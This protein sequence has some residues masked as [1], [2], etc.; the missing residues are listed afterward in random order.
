MVFESYL[1]ALNAE[2][3]AWEADWAADPLMGPAFAAEAMA[4]V[5]GVLYIGINN[6]FAWVRK[7]A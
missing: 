2:T 3:L 1:V 5:D 6:A 4:L 7:W